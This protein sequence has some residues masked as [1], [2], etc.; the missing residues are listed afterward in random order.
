[1]C[2]GCWERLAVG[3]VGGHGV[4]GVA[5]EGDSAGDR[6]LVARQSVRVSGAVPAFVF[7]ADRGG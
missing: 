6:N 2:L 5:D 3:S 1:L 4:V 7:G